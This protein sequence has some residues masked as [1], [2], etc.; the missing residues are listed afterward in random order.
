MTRRILYG[1]AILAALFG[2]WGIYDRI[3]FG[4][5]HATYGS[6]V[7]WGLWVALYLFFTGLAAGTFVFATLDYLFRVPLFARTGRLSLFLSLI[8]LGAGLLHIWL[9]LGRPERIWKAYLQ[10]NFNSVMNQIVWGYTIFGLIIVIML[11]MSFQPQRYER[12]LKVLSAIGLFLALFLSG[13]VGALLGVQAARP[14]WHVGLFPVQF[15]FFS[16]ASGA[17]LLLLVYG[18]FDRAAN[19]HRRALLRTLAILTLVLQGIKLYFLWA[20]FSQSVYGGMPMNVAAVNEVMFGRYWWAFWILQIFLGSIIPIAILLWPHLSTEPPWAALAGF[21]VLLGFAAARANIVFPALSV[22]ELP[23]L[24]GAFHSSR[25]QFHYFPS[26]ME[27]AVSIGISG[28]IG[29]I[30]LIAYDR[31]PLRPEHVRG[32]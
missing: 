25:L 10:P 14:F 16:L 26:L 15:P 19:E 28:L 32:A 12:W 9:D 5:Q 13:G 23:Q 1:L 31:L 4:H 24:I 30:F 29:L 11:G 22:P 27:W 17:A 20:D 8:T 6:Y 7:V 21:L 3:A 2:L 18:L